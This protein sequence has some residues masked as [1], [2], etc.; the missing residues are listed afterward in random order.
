MAIDLRKEHECRKELC[1]YLKENQILFGEISPNT[2]I[3]I[4][5]FLLEWEKKNIDTSE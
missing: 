5:D 1:K 2:I 3:E 4:S